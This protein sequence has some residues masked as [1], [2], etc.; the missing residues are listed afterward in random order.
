MKKLKKWLSILLLRLSLF[1]M[2]PEVV[3]QPEVS[4]EPYEEVRIH[5][6][7]EH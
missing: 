3:E 4:P 7:Y 6:G 5:K 2:P 1:I